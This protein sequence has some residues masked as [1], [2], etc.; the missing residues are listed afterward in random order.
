MLFGLCLSLWNKLIK[1]HFSDILLEFIPQLVFL[2]FIFCYLLFMIFYKWTHYYADTPTKDTN[3]YSEHCAPPL[4]I[5]FINMML[6]KPATSDPKL[7]AI[8][9]GKE[10]YMYPGQHGIQMFLVVVGVLM[11]PVMLFGKPVYKFAGES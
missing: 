5:T 8:C 9:Q 7:H 10:I 6:F 11:I 3:I 2:V 4:L 1:K